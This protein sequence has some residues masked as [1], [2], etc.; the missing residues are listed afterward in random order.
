VKEDEREGGKE[1]EEISKL[2][3]SAKDG[4][5]DALVDLF[6]IYI[7]NLSQK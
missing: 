5:E 6:K 1:C 4:D 3:S 7:K 2:V